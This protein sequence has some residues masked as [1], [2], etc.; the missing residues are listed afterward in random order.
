MKFCSLLYPSIFSQNGCHN[1][2]LDNL[3]L[4][5][6]ILLSSI[7]PLTFSTLFC[8]PTFNTLLNDDLLSCN[9]MLQGDG[10]FPSC[11]FPVLLL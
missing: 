1:I 5:K 10:L 9:H 4:L 2:P 8:C 11:L 3:H 7:T 6:I